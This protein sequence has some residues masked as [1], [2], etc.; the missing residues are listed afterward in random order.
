[1]VSDDISAPAHV[2]GLGRLRASGPAG[3]TVVLLTTSQLQPHC[4]GRR[5]L[6]G[7]EAAAAGGGGCCCWGRRLLLSRLA[8]P[9]ARQR[10]AGAWTL[11]PGS[12]SRHCCRWRSTAGIVVACLLPG[13]QSSGRRVAQ[14][15]LAAVPAEP[16]SASPAGHQQIQ[17]TFKLLAI[18]GYYCVPII[19]N[20][21]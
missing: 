13:W 16:E 3:S 11:R 4:W 2:F 5:L 8:C 7:E 9:A 19:A 12:A 10:P 1:M 18:I 15:P 6:Q 14:P 21:Q 20:N 17:I